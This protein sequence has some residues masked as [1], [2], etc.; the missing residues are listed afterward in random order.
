VVRYRPTH[1]PLDE[2]LYNDADI[3]G[4]KLIWAREMDAAKN[5]EL[6]DYYRGRKAWLIEPDETPVRV[7]PYTMQ[8]QSVAM[9]SH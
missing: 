4:S 5:V 8:Q 7:S 3:D 2:W 9:S 1:E 6:L